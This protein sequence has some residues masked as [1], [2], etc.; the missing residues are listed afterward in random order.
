[1]YHGNKRKNLILIP[2]QFV[3]IVRLTVVIGDKVYSRQSKK[4]GIISNLPIA[5]PN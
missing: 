5:L 2:R 1:M 4:R 3:S